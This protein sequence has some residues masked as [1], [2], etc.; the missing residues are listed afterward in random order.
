MLTSKQNKIT[1]VSFGMHFNNVCRFLGSLDVPVYLTIDTMKVGQRDL[2]NI[3]DPT[4]QSHYK[5]V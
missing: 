1:G 5:S 4:V 3:R 2:H